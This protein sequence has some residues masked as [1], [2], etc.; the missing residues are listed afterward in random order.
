MA[1]AAVA[2]LIAAGAAVSAQEMLNPA[3]SPASG[4]IAWKTVSARNDLTLAS[5]TVDHAPEGW[6]TV[7]EVLVGKIAAG[8]TC[9]LR[10]T[11]SRGQEVVA[12]GWTVAPGRDQ[13]RAVERRCLLGHRGTGR[14]THVPIH[15]ARTAPAGS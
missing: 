6:G 3:A 7:L 11:N 12:C 9:Q 15:P 10:V 14:R 4:Q 8:T 1:A 13:W 2:V 5:A